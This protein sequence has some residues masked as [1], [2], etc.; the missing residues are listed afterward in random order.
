MIKSFAF[1]IIY[2]KINL[3]VFGQPQQQIRQVFQKFQQGYSIRDTSLA[4]AF[5]NDLFAKEIEIIGTGEDEWIDG[6]A[7][8][9]RFFK[10][11]WATWLNLVI[12]TSKINVAVHDNAAFFSVPGTASISFP[13]KE[14]AYRFALNRLQQMAGSESSDQ[15]KLLTYS[16]KASDLIREIESGGLAIN[17]LI[18]LTGGLLRQNGHWYFNQ[19]VFSFPYPMTRK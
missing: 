19:L 17:Y 13:D 2:F 3:S 11:D 9:T 15:H 5:V 10:S 1:L 6:K 18:R 12:D 7:A 4:D 14:S 16:A 8:A